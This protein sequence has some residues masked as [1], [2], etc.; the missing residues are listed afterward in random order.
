ML[1]SAS[2]AAAQHFGDDNQSGD[3]LP[4]PDGYVWAK[5]VSDPPEFKAKIKEFARLPSAQREG[6]MRYWPEDS[7][8]RQVRIAEIDLNA[9]EKPEL[10]VAVPAYGG[11][12]GT[13]YEILSLT[14]GKTYQGIGGIQG[15][16]F[17][18]LVRKNGWLQIEGMS[19]GGGGNYTRYLM[20][21]AGT[22]YEITRNE[23]HDF[24]ARKVTVRK[25][26]AEQ[27]GADRPATDPESKQEGDSKP[28]P[29]SKGH[30]Q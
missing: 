12:G 3:W 23:G 21:F 2:S 20:T 24:N 10:F 27:D 7:A 25:T 1:A 9:D 11:T 4:I 28:Q 15:W 6:I 14:D 30:A 16:G 17:Q 26:K 19:R 5:V 18:F 22:G 13:F 29:E 8:P